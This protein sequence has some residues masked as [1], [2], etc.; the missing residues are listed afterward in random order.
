MLA[1]FMVSVVYYSSITGT[2]HVTLLIREEEQESS[3][4]LAKVLTSKTNELAI[5]AKDYTYWD[6]MVQFTETHDTLWAA[7]NLKV[8]LETYHADYVWVFGSNYERFYFASGE[9]APQL[10][11]DILTAEILRTLE[12]ESSIFHFFINTNIGTIEICG[13]SIH[14]TTDPQRR[15]IP[16]GYFAAGRL[17]NGKILSDIAEYTGS[18]I[19]I[20]APAVLTEEENSSKMP[21]HIK[22]EYTLLSWNNKPAAVVVPREKEPLVEAIRYESGIQL[23]LMLGFVVVFLGFLSTSLYFLVNRPVKNIS[24]S[25]KSNDTKYLRGLVNKK[26]EFG[27]MSRLVNE[28]FEQKEKLV[29]EIAERIEAEARAKETEVELRNSLN[30]KVILLK[31]VHHRV[32]NNLQ[33]IISLIRL[34]ADTLGN[35]ASAAQLNAILSRIRSIAFVHELLYRSQ[36]LGRIDFEEYVRKF[37]ISLI[38]MYNDGSKRI[39]LKVDVKD[40]HIG[41]DLAVPCGII[42]N[43]LVTNSMKH[44]FNGSSSGTISIAMQAENGMYTLTVSDSGTSDPENLKSKS[45]ASLGM[46]LVTSLAEQLEAELDIRAGKNTAFTFKFADV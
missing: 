12:Q 45:P 37:T 43:E 25:L 4:L 8:S 30:E 31:E 11:S 41:V 42:I 7:R 39:E 3:V 27:E 6:E 22:S 32:K 21:L 16:R 9:E 2:E 20:E 17:W 38:D 36:D 34:Q 15:T 19:T 14:P 46:Y 24:E 13:A 23:K 26:D 5:F 28:F 44:A 40:I 18:I 35:K 1:V 33:V 29:K 10:D